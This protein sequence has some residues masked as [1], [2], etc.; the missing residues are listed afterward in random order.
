VTYTPPFHLKVVDYGEERMKPPVCSSAVARTTTYF[1]Q[2]KLRESRAASPYANY[3][4]IPISSITA[5]YGH[6]LIVDPQPLLVTG[7]THDLDLTEHKPAP[8]PSL[9]S[10]TTC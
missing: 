5:R 10:S 4:V 9:V 3:L 7:R 6:V 2:G 8:H 1:L